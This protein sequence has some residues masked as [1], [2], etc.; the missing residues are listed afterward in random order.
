MDR[1]TFEKKERIL[2]TNAEFP[3]ELF[4]K[5]QKSQSANLIV[6]PSLS[7][8]QDAFR[9]F[10]KNGQSIFAFSL[11][12]ILIVFSF[13][14]PFFWTKDPAQQNLNSASMSPNLGENA[15]VIDESLTFTP[16]MAATDAVAA[17]V[18][19]VL[20]AVQNF[21]VKGQPN[22]HSVILTW[23][24]LPGASGYTI[25][26]NEVKPEEGNYGVPLGDIAD[27]QQISFED[28][29][30]LE[31]REYYYVIIPKDASGVETTLI[32]QIKLKVMSAITV[33]AAKGIGFDA[34][35]GSKVRLSAAPLGTD[36][37]G[38]DILARLM[39]GGRV[40]LFIGIIASFFS[41]IIGILI[42]GVS[43]FFGGNIDAFV[44][45]FTDL[46]SGLPFLLFMILLKVILNVGPG[47]SGI[48]A[49]LISLVILSWT[50]TAR[51]VRGQILQIRNSE[52]IQASRMM[53]AKPF[54][55]IVRHMLPNLIGVILV[56]LTFQI[57]SAIFTE[58]FLSFIGLGVAAPATSWGAMCQDALQS[59]LI[60]PYEFFAPAIVISMTVLSFNLLG[61]GLRDA[62]DPKLRSNE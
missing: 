20:T 45:R 52:F 33:E 37:L 27:P 15:I 8:W 47:E 56:S 10:R 7:Y 54:Y 59:L 49:M 3:Q 40:S 55:L 58:A 22:T 28:T 5:K 62:L 43:G 44:M 25:Y 6:R 1:T 42:G 36:A 53:G 41:V 4:Q 18:G 31:A 29:Q 21:K 13:I 50:G 16:D 23:D 35:V 48:A 60:H 57:P 17:T 19:S 39:Y 51:L 61:D 34:A 30:S 38:R 14:G 9:R 26:R 46:V 11:A 12:M 32:S 2:T 24:Y